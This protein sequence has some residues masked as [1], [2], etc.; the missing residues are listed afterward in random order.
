MPARSRS[1]Q[2]GIVR[3]SRELVVVHIGQTSLCSLSANRPMQQASVSFHV[4]GADKRATVNHH[5][6]VTDM[7]NLPQFGAYAAAFEKTLLD[8]DWSRLEQYFANDSIYLPGDGTQSDGRDAAIQALK[9]SVSRL[10]RKCDTREL[11]GEPQIKE[12]GDTVTLKYSMR[13]GRTDGSSF[14]LNGVETIDYANGKI[15][16]M[17]DVFEDPSALEAW[18]SKT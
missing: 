1:E 4:I 10:E 13:Y 15:A 2:L 9:D 18:A 5:S 7:S 14:V 6:R 16:R 11:V 3:P 8:D 12:S 17:E